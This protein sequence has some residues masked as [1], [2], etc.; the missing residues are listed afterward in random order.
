MTSIYLHRTYTLHCIHVQAPW[1]LSPVPQQAAEAR[2]Y[3]LE[4]EASDE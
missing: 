1:P 4:V 3:Y 2:E